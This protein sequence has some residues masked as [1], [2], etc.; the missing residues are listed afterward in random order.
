[1]ADA[2]PIAVLDSGVGGVSVLRELIARMPA[3]DFLYFGDAANA[4]Y[5]EKR[6]GEV[7]ALT[8][9]NAQ[10]LFDMGA[11][12]LVVAC[13]TATGA[14]IGALRERFA[15]VPV[16]G[17]EPALKPAALWRQ[18]GTVLV[19]ATPLTLRQEKFE[20]LLA[21]YD[22]RARILTLPCHGL[23]ELIEQGITDGAEMDALLTG[24][25]APLKGETIDAAVLGCTHYPLAKAA[26]RRALGE[27]V[28]LF[29]GGAGTARQTVRRLAAAGLLTHR[30]G[31]GRVYWHSSGDEAGFAALGERLLTGGGDA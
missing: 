20:Q 25:F 14:A 2:R 24:L 3:E 23:V 11:K 8:L 5:G 1:M 22:R 9:H 15:A 10:A 13:N 12:A 7:R 29:D 16:I 19:M 30:Q 31:K 26:I 27:G 4:P 18:G 28:A 6:A 17:I 21:R